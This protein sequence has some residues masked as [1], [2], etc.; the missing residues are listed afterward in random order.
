M[1]MELRVPAAAAVRPGGHGVALAGASAPG[2]ASGQPRVTPALLS[3]GFFS[4]IEE[5]IWKL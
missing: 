1:P 2:A 3:P 4:I 5:R